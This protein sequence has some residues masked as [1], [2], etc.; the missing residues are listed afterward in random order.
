MSKS[1]ILNEIGWVRSLFLATINVSWGGVQL[2]YFPTNHKNFVRPAYLIAI[3][4]VYLIIEEGGFIWGYTENSWGPC[5]VVSPSFQ[6]LEVCI[7]K[8]Q[9][10]H[11]H[12]RKESI[13][14]T[15]MTAGA[16][17]NQS[18]TLTLCIPRSKLSSSP[19]DENLRTRGAIRK[20]SQSIQFGVCPMSE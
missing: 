12:N 1:S 15:S 9:K 18:W 8:T 16:K 14:Y 20:Y 6:Q 13:V 11:Y 4:R 5:Q 10:F 3:R 2:P 17:V 19:P 7:G